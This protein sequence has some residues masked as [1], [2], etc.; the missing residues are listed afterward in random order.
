M[1]HMLNSSY[2]QFLKSTSK[3]TSGGPSNMDQIGSLRKKK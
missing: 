2:L 3:G 1:I